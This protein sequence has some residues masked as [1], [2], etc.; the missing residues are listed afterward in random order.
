MRF[1]VQIVLMV[2][3]AGRYEEHIVAAGLTLGTV[4]ALSRLRQ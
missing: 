1:R 3:T 4:H 2:G